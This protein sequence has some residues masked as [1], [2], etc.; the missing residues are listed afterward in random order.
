MSIY[1][2]VKRRMKATA[3]SKIAKEPK[4]QVIN[5][6]SVFPLRTVTSKII[7]LLSLQSHLDKKITPCSWSTTFNGSSHPFGLKTSM[8][9]MK[10]KCLILLFKDI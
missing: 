6:K 3:I 9:K 4:L 5:I 10:K 8:M 1:Y 2:V 7:N